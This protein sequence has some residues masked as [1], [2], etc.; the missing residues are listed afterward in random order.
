M[1]NIWC[2][3]PL[4]IGDFKLGQDFKENSSFVL[5]NGNGRK[6]DLVLSHEE[7][8]DYWTLTEGDVRL[9]IGCEKNKSTITSII[10]L[11]KLDQKF[12]NQLLDEI[13]SVKG[14]LVKLE[15]GNTVTSRYFW[16][17][18]S[19]VTVVKTKKNSSGISKL[20]FYF[21]ESMLDISPGVTI[22]D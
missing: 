13:L 7:I 15:K 3:T 1:V 6:L 19:R 10:V 21:T 8:F 9:L 11:D 5:L 18:S 14:E 16:S 12:P 4:G 2:I 22:K 17:L 20:Q